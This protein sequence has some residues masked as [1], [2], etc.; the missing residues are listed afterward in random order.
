MKAKVIAA[1]PDRACSDWEAMLLP[2]Y[3]PNE[4]CSG[5]AAALEVTADVL[6][7]LA[8]WSGGTDAWRAF[9]WWKH[10]RSRR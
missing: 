4:D 7:Y 2:W 3:R 10:E 5:L 9:E 6:G 8:L 1:F